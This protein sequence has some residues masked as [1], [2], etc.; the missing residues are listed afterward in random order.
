MH[1]TIKSS[2][3]CL[4]ITSLVTRIINKSVNNNTEYVLT[5]DKFRIRDI[6]LNEKIVITRCK[7]GILT[8]KLDTPDND[9]KSKDIKCLYNFI[10]TQFE[11]DLAS[12]ELSKDT[13]Y[14]DSEDGF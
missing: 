13:N 1:K 4:S 11:K 5:K 14:D 10:L 2:T 8:V 7:N 6:Q 9:I 12:Y 3:R